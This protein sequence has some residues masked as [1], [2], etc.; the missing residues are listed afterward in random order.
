MEHKLG[1][2]LQVQVFLIDVRI[3]RNILNKCLYYYP[4]TLRFVLQLGVL[5]NEGVSTHHEADISI[6]HLRL[7]Y[8]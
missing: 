1:F 8:L 5:P 4:S 3:T 2:R 6:F 7:L